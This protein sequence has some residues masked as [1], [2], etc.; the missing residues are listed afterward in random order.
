[1]ID[2][3]I[4]QW[5]GVVVIM[6]NKCEECPYAIWDYYEYYGHV[7]EW[8]VDGCK[9]GLDENECDDDEE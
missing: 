8:F 9:K 3:Y 4:K 6:A 1:M 2:S 7:K 5:I